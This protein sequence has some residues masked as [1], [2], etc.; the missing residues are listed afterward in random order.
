VLAQA[1][2]YVFRMRMAMLRGADVGFSVPF[3]T[4]MQLARFTGGFFLQRDNT[5]THYSTDFIP[6]NAQY[7]F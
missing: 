7:R 5:L 1:L 4:E 2:Q 6:A 3:N